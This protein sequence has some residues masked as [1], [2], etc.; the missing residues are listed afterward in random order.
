MAVVPRTQGALSWEL[1]PP[2]P[3]SLFAVLLRFPHRDL[4]QGR[5]GPRGRLVGGELLTEAA[6]VQGQELGE[7]AAAESVEEGRVGR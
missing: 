4:T 3:G 5:G 7:A 2:P 1:L 6:Q